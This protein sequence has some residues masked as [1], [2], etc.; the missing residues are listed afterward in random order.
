MHRFWHDASC[1][2]QHTRHGVGPIIVPSEHSPH[3]QGSSP[4]K[5]H[6]CA[7]SRVGTTLVHHIQMLA[8]RCTNDCAGDNTILAI[9]QPV[10]LPTSTAIADCL[11]PAIETRHWLNAW[12]T[13]LVRIRNKA[14]AQ[15]WVNAYKLSSSYVYISLFPTDILE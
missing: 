4:K 5:N 9:M 14:L 15:H 8:Q 2:L 6:Q 12:S 1:Q 7:V 13:L 3:Q 10:L 11:C